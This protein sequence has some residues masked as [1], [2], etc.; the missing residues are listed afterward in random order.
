[1]KIYE[2]YE[3]VMFSK[4]KL[5]H[6]IHDSTSHGV[7]NIIIYNNISHNFQFPSCFLDN[8]YFVGIYV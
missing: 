7:H 6:I 1:M 5:W 3:K 4:E 8:T 2:K